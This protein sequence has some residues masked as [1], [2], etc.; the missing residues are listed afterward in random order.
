MDSLLSDK[1]ASGAHRALDASLSRVRDV[2][3]K[4]GRVGGWGPGLPI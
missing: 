1:V 2:R 3:S 4:G